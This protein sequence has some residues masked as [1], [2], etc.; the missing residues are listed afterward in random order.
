MMFPSILSMILNKFDTSS[1]NS[2]ILPFKL[3]FETES[4]KP[5]AEIMKLSHCFEGRMHVHCGNF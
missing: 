1:S 4:R 5:A 2:N 3:N